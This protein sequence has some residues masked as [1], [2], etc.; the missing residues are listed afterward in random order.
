MPDVESP[1]DLNARADA[2]AAIYD[3]VALLTSE[4]IDGSN[5]AGGGDPQAVTY[6]AGG[7]EGPTSD[8]AAIDGIAWSGVNDFDL[9]EEAT[10]VGLLVGG[11]MFRTQP[12]RH[13]V[14]PGPVPFVHRV[15]P[16]A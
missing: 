10:H 3:E 2:V 16:A 11:V 6:F 7:V 12:L 8:H 4:G 13:K 14:G 15:G 5:V 1:A 9:S